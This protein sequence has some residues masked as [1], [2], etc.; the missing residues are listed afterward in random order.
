MDGHFW[1][2]IL[3]LS[4]ASSWCDIMCM[5]EIQQYH[6]WYQAILSCREARLE[7]ML[8][9]CPS[10]HPG[11]TELALSLSARHQREWYQIT[12]ET[13]SQERIFRIQEDYLQEH[14]SVTNA[15]NAA[16]FYLHS[17]V[18]LL[19]SLTWKLPCQVF[20]SLLSQSKERLAE[21]TALNAPFYV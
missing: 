8:G 20:Q 6:R 13:Q 14:T 7:S 1:M 5:T 19:K 12:C 3:V 18:Y 4:P 17:S 16:K 21:E 2:G 9:Q 11:E 15:A 10:N